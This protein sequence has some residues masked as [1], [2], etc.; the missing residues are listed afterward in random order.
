[1]IFGL[2]KASIGF[3]LIAMVCAIALPMLAFVALLLAQLQIN[4]R[5]ALESRTEREAQSL[6]TGINRT[7]QEMS[8]TLKL[9]VTSP[10]LD[11]GDLE[12]F[13]NRAQAALRTGSL[14]VILV[15]ENGQQL[16]NTRVPYGSDLGKT[17]NLAALQ[18]AVESGRTEASDVFL[19]MTSGKWVFNVTLP[20]PEELADK[21]AALILTKNADELSRLMSPEGLPEGWSAAI[22]DSAGYVVA[23][24]DNPGISRENPFDDALLPQFTRFRGVV[25]DV[26]GADDN[27]VGYARLLGWDWTAIVWGPVATA[28]ASILTTWQMLIFGGTSL[29]AIALAAAIFLARQ[30]RLSIQGIADMA[31]HVGRGEVVSPQATQIRELDRVAEA[32]SVASFDRSQAEDQIRLMLREMAHR[33]KNLLAVLQA[34]INQ[35]ARNAETVE[36]LES[37]ISQR[38]TALGKST[39]LL[40]AKEI[41]GVPIRRVIDS[42]LSTF[43]ADADHLEIS[44][45]DFRLRAESVQNLGLVLHELSTNAVKYG[46]LSRPE[47]RVRISWEIHNVDSD[48]PRLVL[49]WHERGGPPV[50]EPKH[51]G[52][53]TQIMERHAAWTFGGKV[54]VAYGA[55]GLTW[56]LDAPL[57]A[58]V[59]EPPALANAG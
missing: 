18:S 9:L 41:A 49:T 23:A 16:L 5:S 48:A 53:G 47:G 2:P 36:D 7:L 58:F 42:H 14:Y 45:E 32:L 6:A 12:A 34:M 25:Y 39:D 17:S 21:G 31:E 56:T 26:L 44:G 46:A 50:T 13:H 33:T 38:I 29:L 57:R 15:D 54:D 10:E 20:L 22:L 3:F 43:V 28:Q 55:E 27:M 52:F 40:A 37:A 59:E 35:S 11:R 1:M 8:T 24:T 51:K 19:G 4:E 30:L